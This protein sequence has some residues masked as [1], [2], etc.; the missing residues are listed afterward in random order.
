MNMSTKQDS[1]PLP[2]SWRFE[3]INT[4]EIAVMRDGDGNKI[5]EFHNYHHAEYIFNVVNTHAAINDI[6][7]LDVP[8]EEPPAPRPRFAIAG[9]EEALEPGVT[10][11][12]LAYSPGSTGEIYLHCK[13]IPCGWILCIDMYTGK[14]KLMSGVNCDTG[15]P[16]DD[17]G[18]LKVK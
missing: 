4:P 17:Q 15:F 13:N 2:L 1:A 6:A 5:A 8:K 11:L 3:P 16:L 9:T 14:A 12:E 10:V 18:R 7:A